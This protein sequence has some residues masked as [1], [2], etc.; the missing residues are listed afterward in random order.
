MVIVICCLYQKAF[1][2]ISIKMGIQFNLEGIQKLTKNNFS[3]WEKESI[4]FLE[5]YWSMQI[6]DCEEI[7][8]GI[9][10]T[11]KKITDVKKTS[12][13]CRVLK[14]EFILLFFF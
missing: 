14:T 3:S 1:I 7:W 10:L 9:F 12:R 6:L 5:N 4:H 8:W 11:I 13:E 2:Y